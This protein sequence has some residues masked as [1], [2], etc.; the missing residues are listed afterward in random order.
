MIGS[1]RWSTNA[2]METN[3]KLK[4]QASV[5][6]KELNMNWNELFPSDVEPSMNDIAEYIGEAKD[7]WLS[8]T[9]YMETAYQ[10]KPKLSYSGCS[11]KPGWNIKYQ[12][13][14]QCFGTLYPLVN[15]IDCMIIVSY[16]LDSIMNETLPLLSN[17]TADLYRSADDY[18]KIGK[19]M[20][21]R[22]DSE[23]TLEDYKKI[24]AVK[25][26]PKYI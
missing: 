15:A 12:K 3:S 26:P 11:M 6:G 24:V 20:M 16:K 22:I 7:L 23:K 18:M 2:C 10:A 4:I 1:S 19:W 25:M 21:L 5:R 13:S 17:Y 14:V 9:T 8:L